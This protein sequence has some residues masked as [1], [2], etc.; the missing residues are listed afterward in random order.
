MIN[1][2]SGTASRALALGAFILSSLLA[3]YVVI[4][5]LVATF[6]WLFLEHPP[7]FGSALGDML[8]ALFVPACVLVVWNHGKSRGVPSTRLLWQLA[9][10]ALAAGFT[11]AFLAVL[12][13][14]PVP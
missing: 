8:L 13:G 9:G 12:L 7:R 11:L 10:T 1:D 14:P 6:A 5:F 3:A 4:F 2:R